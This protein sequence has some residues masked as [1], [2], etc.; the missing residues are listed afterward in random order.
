M[1]SS[2]GRRGSTQ[3]RWVQVIAVVLASAVILSFVAGALAAI[4]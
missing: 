3:R 1:M 4:L 2:P